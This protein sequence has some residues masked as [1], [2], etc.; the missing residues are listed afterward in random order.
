MIMR[1]EIASRVDS[2]IITAVSTRN[3]QI[4]KEIHKSKV[5]V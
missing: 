4:V 5:Y 1:I 2:V 3:T